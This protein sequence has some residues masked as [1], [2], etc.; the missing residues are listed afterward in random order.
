MTWRVAESMAEAL[1]VKIFDKV[2]KKMTSLSL[3]DHKYY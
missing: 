1:F 3:G 2:V